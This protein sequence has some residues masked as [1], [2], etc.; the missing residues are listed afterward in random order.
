VV[1]CETDLY[2]FYSLQLRVPFEHFEVALEVD[3]LNIVG[4]ELNHVVPDK[5]HFKGL[6]NSLLHYHIRIQ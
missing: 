2:E 3:V 5:S 6:V 1:V 4:N